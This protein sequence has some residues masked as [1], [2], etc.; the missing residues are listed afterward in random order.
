MRKLISFIKYLLFFGVGILL[1]WLVYRNIDRKALVE[2]LRNAN[3]YWVALALLM[4]V[5]SHIVRGR[6]WALLISS[7]G[8]KVSTWHTTLAVFISYLANLAL[9]RMGEISK[10]VAVNRT[11]KIPL[12]KLIGTVIVERGLD[13]LMLLFICFVAFTLEFNKV[14]GYMASSIEYLHNKY[15]NMFSFT[16]LLLIA[17]ILVVIVV[18][19]VLVK[20]SKRSFKQHPFYLK[21]REIVSG[22]WH[23]IKTIAHLD[24]KWE[25]IFHTFFLWILYFLMSYIMLF[26]FDRTAGLSIL[27]GLTV[28]AIGSIGFLM[29]VQG[30]I[31]TYHYAVE[32]ALGIYGID[33]ADAAVYALISHSSQTLLII[34]GGA[35][36]FLII[37]FIQRKSNHEN[38]PG[39]KA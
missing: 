26:A 15:G 4:A 27:A 28:L 37:G 34:I 31:G 2:G 13:F 25:F 23:G 8:T 36:S 19:L 9:P 1:F 11:D 17:L 39:D 14:K 16:T 29:P 22:F 3:Y 5:L 21:T 18:L 33:K 38:L 12:N 24:R 35:V 6:R 30:G 20:K 32:K 10:C 7:M